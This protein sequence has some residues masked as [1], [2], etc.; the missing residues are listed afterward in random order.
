MLHSGVRPYVCL[1]CAAGLLRSAGAGSRYR[2]IAAGAAAYQ[3]AAGA[4]SVMLGT[5]GR[6][7]TQTCYNRPIFNDP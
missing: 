7:S 3:L 1:S 2:S 6:S 5:D 4:G